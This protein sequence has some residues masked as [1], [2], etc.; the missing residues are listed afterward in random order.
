LKV[1]CHS[2]GT[3][4]ETWDF[5]HPDRA[6]KCDCCPLPHDHA[7]LGCRPVTITAT[8]H[9]T[10]FDLSELMDVA[11]GRSDHLPVQQQNTVE[12]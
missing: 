7:G 6:V 8:A 5:R 10:L 11:A 9:L 3:T 4:A 2:C 12:A 1:T